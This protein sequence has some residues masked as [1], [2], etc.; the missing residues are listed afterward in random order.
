MYVRKTAYLGASASPFHTIVEP[1][2]S[3]VEKP[4]SAYVLLATITMKPI[5]IW[6]P[7]GLA[8]MLEEKF[9]SN[10]CGKIEF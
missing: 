1:H 9:G 4:F 5:V 8:N 2:K 10:F 3:D 6:V 7:C